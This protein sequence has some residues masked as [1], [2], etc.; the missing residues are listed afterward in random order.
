MFEDGH[1][2]KLRNELIS[3]A[4]DDIARK[5]TCKEI[6]WFLGKYDIDYD[7]YSYLSWAAIPATNYYT[8]TVRIRKYVSM[9]ANR[10]KEALTQATD[11]MIEHKDELPE[12]TDAL[13]T[14]GAWIKRLN[15]VN[16]PAVYSQNEQEEKETENDGEE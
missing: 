7:E 5:G 16:D 6:R 13:A 1:H 10:L 11:G 12:L 2:V 8:D 3:Y 4:V 15:G 14:L 9:C